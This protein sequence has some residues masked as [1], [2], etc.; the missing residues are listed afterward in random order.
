MS[1]EWHYAKDGQRHGP[2]TTRQLKELA[3]SGDLRPTD[4]VWTDGR[5]EWKPASVVMGLFPDEVERKQTPPDI[6][7]ALVGESQQERVSFQ[8]QLASGGKYATA[9]GGLCGFAADLLTPLGPFNG[10]L[11]I[12]AALCCITFFLMWWRLAPECR[13]KWDRSIPNQALIFSVYLLLAFG[14][15]FGAAKLSD[16]GDNGVLGGNV[17]VVAQMQRTL[18]GLESTV[19][20]IKSDTGEILSETKKISGNI[21]ELGKLGGLIKEAT[22]P[23]DF[24]HNARVHELSG[25]FRQAF[26]AYERYVS[27]DQPFVDPIDSYLTLLKSQHGYQAAGQEFLKLKAQFPS[28]RAI[29]LV[30]IRLQA[31]QARLD[32][33]QQFANANPEYGPVTLDLADFYSA[34][35]MPNRSGVDVAKEGSYLEKMLEANATGKFSSYFLDKKLAD[36]LLADARGRLTANDDVGR[37]L[38]SS[39]MVTV[40]GGGRFSGGSVSV[41]DNTATKIFYSFDQN[42][43]KT[44]PSVQR[45]T[46]VACVYG[47]IPDWGIS[48]K[49]PDFVYIKYL[50]HRGQE[51]RVFDFKVD[52]GKWSNRAKG[53]G[54]EVDSGKRYKPAEDYRDSKFY[55]DAM[56]RLR[57]SSPPPD[58]LLP[59]E[60]R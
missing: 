26:D 16:S 19:Q 49:P 18:L 55:K 41:M 13:S 54:K 56:K 44:V 60:D 29:E 9:I 35:Q 46:T 45:L 48:D 2:I 38:R 6:H 43:W 20:D 3:A 12:V 36:S 14:V 47:P 33:L 32:A 11:A 51:S 59:G 5:D 37:T 28:S 1:Q 58:R 53:D 42:E 40:F 34:E 4:L 22:T 17:A 27:F 21:D 39:Q 57:L 24:Y 8:S 15:W 31:G 10:Y 23:S 52:S 7:V 30:S 50:D 25:D